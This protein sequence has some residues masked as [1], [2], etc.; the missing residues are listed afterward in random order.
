MKKVLKLL[1]I[2]FISNVFFYTREDF[3][4]KYGINYMCFMK[5]NGI[6]CAIAECLKGA[7]FPRENFIKL[8]RPFLPM[9]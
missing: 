3:V 5:Y 9:L 8:Q 1:L 4:E 7:H 2:F 6:I